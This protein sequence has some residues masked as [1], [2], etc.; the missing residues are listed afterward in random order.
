M[1]QL[2]KLLIGIVLIG[3]I[4]SGLI[5]F[6]NSGVQEYNPASYDDTSF[7][8]FD[9]LQNL[10]EDMDT[11]RAEEDGVTTDTNILDI[12][13]SFFTN[14][15]QSAKVFRGSVDVMGSMVDESIDK[16]P[17]AGSY[18]TVLKSGFNLMIAITIFIGI[19]LAFV[20]KSE[21]T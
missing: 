5:L 7:E 17:S 10:T 1:L 15:Y 21:R 8:S 2:H 18:S 4:S 6:L 14:M 20:T 11:F 3:M 12:L 9:K 13:G 16:V 19:F